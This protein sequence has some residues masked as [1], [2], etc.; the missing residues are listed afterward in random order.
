M[1]G[2][3]QRY[4]TVRVTNLNP[5][6]ACHD[7]DIRWLCSYRGERTCWFVSGDSTAHQFYSASAAKS[8]FRTKDLSHFVADPE[9]RVDI[10]ET[11]WTPA[12]KVV[13][14]TET[15]AIAKL[16]LIGDEA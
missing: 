12:H 15:D 13:H 10:I 11:T 7:W 5:D 1:I 3:P 9:F 4:F 14:T 8:K 2:T 16:A 6:P